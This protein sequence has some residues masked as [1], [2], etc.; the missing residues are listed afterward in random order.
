MIALLLALLPQAPQAIDLASTLP[1]DGWPVE[2]VGVPGTMAVFGPRT[3]V[4]LCSA[5][6]PPQPIAAGVV[7][8]RGRAFAIA[9]DGYLRPDLMDRPGGLMEAAMSWLLRDVQSADGPLRV[10]LLGASAGLADHLTS[11]G[12]EVS[13]FDRD[14]L[15]DKHLL[16]IS[17]GGPQLPADLSA[18]DA[19]LRGGG[20]LLA[21]ICPWGWQQI[22]ATR[23]WRL[24]GDLAANQ[25]LAPHGL[26]FTAELA[27]SAGNDVFPINRSANR[28]ANAWHLT[29]LLESAAST[30]RA[31]PS[32][33]PLESALGTLPLDDTLLLPRLRSLL[34]ELDDRNAPSPAHPLAAREQGL[35]RLAVVAENRRLRES[36]SES[37]RTAPGA[38]DFPGTVPDDAPRSVRSLRFDA[39]V[40]G[41]HSTG[42]YLAP[43][44]ELRM[45]VHSPDPSQWR[46]RIGCH[47]DN[48]WHKSHWQ[49]WPN[50]SV[51]GRLA[52]SPPVAPTAA[53]ESGT[54]QMAEVVAGS[55]F[56]GLIYLEPIGSPAQDLVLEIHGATAAPWWRRGQTSAAQWHELRTAPAPWAEL[57]GE[58]LILTV[59]SA[60][61]RNLEDPAPLMEWWDRVVAEQF[62]LGSEQPAP[63]PERFVTDIQ[64]SA[65]YM[66]AGY[67]IMM[68]LDVAQARADGRPAVLLDLEQLRTHGNWGAFHELGHNR[69]KPTWTFAGTGEVTNNLFALFAGEVLS[70][71]EPWHNPWLEPQKK[72][73]RNY[74]ASGAEFAQWKRSPGIALVC[75][76]EVVRA[77]GWDPIRTVFR[78]AANLPADRAPASDA[79]KRDFWVR[80]LSGACDRDLR[81]FHRAW[82]W[83]L[84]QSL[85]T[86]PALDALPA[87]KPKRDW[88]E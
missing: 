85:L 77:F 18:I 68:G 43:G 7:A 9:H 80:E 8:G 63:R 88:T 50:I 79:D 61:V 64:I 67:P 45:I 47:V 26:L 33:A 39:R 66:H 32:L 83:P 34:P 41:W 84:S 74:L 58:H 19:W 36:K 23:G 12:F 29:S 71:I 40:P 86:D 5:D 37:G 44:D 22:N 72:A 49:R 53:G 57:Q 27:R 10:A 82:G 3:Q 73:A 31:L 15:S 2:R 17:H 55:P 81:P 35:L 54:A 76:A 28:M 14:H 38:R 4:A 69:Q 24:P 87:W 13:A 46:Y 11:Q 62:A 65:G 70:D 52:A 6:D 48:L 16:I 25:I 51:T 56:G 75:Y 60:A 78:T 21:A 1:P 42:L 59:P 30:G 20:S